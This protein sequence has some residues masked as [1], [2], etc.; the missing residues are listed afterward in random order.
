[1]ALSTLGVGETVVGQSLSGEQSFLG[2]QEFGGGR[3]V[4]QDHPGEAADE[5]SSD[6]LDQEEPSPALQ[7]PGAVEVLSDDTG[8]QTGESTRDSRGSV[9]DG[10]TTSDLVSLVPGGQ[11]EGD[12]RGKTCLGNTKSESD[13]GKLLPV[14]GSGHAG[15]DTTPLG[16]SQ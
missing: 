15:R 6:T 8:E 2:R 7:T 9:V 1:M 16:K 12:T 11:V 5:R 14:V 4:G 13:T 3:V 10:E